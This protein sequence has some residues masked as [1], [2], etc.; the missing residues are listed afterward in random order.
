MRLQKKY[1]I[2]LVLAL[3][4]VAL[5]ISLKRPTPISADAGEEPPEQMMM[6]KKK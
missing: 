4:V 2:A 6:M 1:L 3:A 5:V